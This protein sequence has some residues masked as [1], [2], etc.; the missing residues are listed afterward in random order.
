MSLPQKLKNKLQSLFAR[1]KGWPRWLRWTLAVVLVLSVPIAWNLAGKEEAG[2]EVNVC[3]VEKQDLERAVFTNGCL[4]AEEQQVFFSPVESTLMEL[5]VKLGDHVQQGQV[6]GRLDTLEL[7]RKYQEAL[8]DL[9]N[10]EAE[11]IKARSSDDGQILQEAEAAYT[12][13]KNRRERVEALYSAGAATR[14]EMETAEVDMQR[15]QTTYLEAR[16][17]KEGGAAGKQSAALQSQVDLAR[18]AVA[19]AK[20]RLDL[21]TFVAAFDGVV[22][23]VGVKEGNRVLEGTELLVLSNDR[24]MQITSRVNE[25][26]AGE[27]R[28]GQEAVIT[29]MAMPGQKFNGEITRVGGAA[30]QEKSDKGTNVMKV[31]VTVRLKGDF[32]PLKLGYTVD[33]T[34]KTMEVK[35][36]QTV[37]VEVVMEDNSIK[38]AW[39]LKDGMLEERVIE[40]ER[41]NELKD[42]VVSGLAEGDEVVKNPSREWK[43]GDKA[44]AS[45]EE[46]KP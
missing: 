11:L 31:P 35:Q 20:E 32:E 5:N 27:L 13:A 41:G 4:E 19:Q 10:K 33:M 17:K 45:P 39:V 30:V 46:K 1:W 6:L 15:A 21:A 16:A 9:S 7:G 25:V 44:V 14:E 3:R 42:I 23:S 26:D 40:T 36:V 34:I 2:I 37:P 38:K 43:P 24:T 12:K 28:I 22:T 18:Q 8:A 29:C